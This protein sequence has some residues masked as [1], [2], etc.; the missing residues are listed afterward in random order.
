M[1]RIFLAIAITLSISI[2]AQADDAADSVVARIHNAAVEACSP[3]RAL[4]INPRSHYGAIDK[5]C[6]YRIAQSAKVQFQDRNAAGGKG[7]KLVNN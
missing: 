5:A 3:D 2:P 1:V 6:I 4:R 7:S